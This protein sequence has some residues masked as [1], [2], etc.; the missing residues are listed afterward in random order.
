MTDTDLTALLNRLLALPA[1]TE[2]LEFK[3]AGTSFGLDDLGRYFSA[4]SNEA[5]LH[6]QD[7]AWLVFGMNDKRQA[8]GPQYRPSCPGLDSLKGEVAAKTSHN[9]SFIDIHEVLYAGQ[10]LVLHEIPPALPG[11]PTAWQGH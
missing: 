3:T 7:Q 2:L 6:R 9:L 4:R 10:R 1:E 11:V 8:V 5:N